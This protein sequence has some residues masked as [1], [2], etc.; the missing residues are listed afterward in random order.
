VETETQRG[1][2]LAQ[3]S[4]NR[5]RI[6]LVDDNADAAE[7]LTELL[8]GV[9]HEVS[10]AHDGPQAL[11]ES[12]GFNPDVAVL[13][14]GLPVMDGYE[15]AR[16]LVATL[17][18]RPFMIALTGYGQENDRVRAREAG[19]DEHIVK[20]V[21]PERLIEVIESAALRSVSVG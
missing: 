3:L 13:D 7:L 2:P 20:P 18:R 12:A 4:S 1:V 6:L 17:G 19:F 5:R 16:R 9:G 15:L 21:D 10:V 11:I 8:R 14:I